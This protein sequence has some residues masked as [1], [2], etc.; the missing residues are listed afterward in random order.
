[1]TVELETQIGAY[2]RWLEDRAGVPLRK[3]TVSDTGVTFDGTDAATELE[4]GPARPN[5][6]QRRQPFRSLALVAAAVVTLVGAG[7]IAT[8]VRS[9][10]P[11]VSAGSNGNVRAEVTWYGLAADTPLYRNDVVKNEGGLLLCRQPDDLDGCSS[12]VGS[13]SVMYAPSRVS[14]ETEY[15][16]VDSAG[17]QMLTQSAGRIDVAG[18]PGFVSRDGA[19]AGFEPS[20]GVRVVVMA[21]PGSPTVDILRSLTRQSTV[22]E[23]PVVIGDTT[24][25]EAEFPTSVG[26]VARYFAAFADARRACIGGVGIPWNNEPSCV[27]AKLDTLRVITASPSPAGTILVATVPNPATQVE[28]SV[29]GQDPHVLPI[30]ESS[31]GYRVV[32]ADLDAFAPDT[33]TVFGADGVPIGSTPIVSTGGA[34]LGYVQNEDGAGPRVSATSRE[35]AALVSRLGAGVPLPP[36]SSLDQIAARMLPDF[37]G[38]ESTMTAIIEFNAACRW[39]T[40]W[41]DSN[42]RG[43]AVAEADAQSHLDGLAGRTALFAGDADGGVAGMWRNIAAAARAGNPAGVNDAGYRVNCTDV[44]LQQPAG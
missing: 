6:P 17:W 26:P 43:D 12:L 41:L 34:P 38:A 21:P 19:L 35:M 20:P 8:R 32:F 28:A 4:L 14:I 29:G 18:T 1:M 23:L 31:A 24:A 13:R 16:S 5:R 15:G 36:G 33:L 10:E 22:V 42:A 25:T 2:A 9:A 37:S 3:P 27:D 11:A 7:V 44:S 39:T 30:V 40:Y